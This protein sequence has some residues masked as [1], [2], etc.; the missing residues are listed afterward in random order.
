LIELPKPDLIHLS[1][2]AFKKMKKLKIFI[3]RNA[4]FSEESNFLFTELRLLDWPNYPRESLPSNVCA[5]NLVVLTMPRSQLKELKGVQ[6]KLL[7]LIFLP[8]D[9]AVITSFKLIYFLFFFTEFPE[10]DN[11]GFP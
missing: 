1:P 3:N 9:Y 7:F 2:K 11:Y 8:L 6:V 5:K 4:R 10:L